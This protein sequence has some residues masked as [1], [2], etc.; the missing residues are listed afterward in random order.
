[1]E[2]ILP[3]IIGISIVVAYYIGKCQGF[4]DGIKGR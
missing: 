1:M 4:K 2:R 3:A